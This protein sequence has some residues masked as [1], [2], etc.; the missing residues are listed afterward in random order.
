M[1]RTGQ[2]SAMSKTLPLHLLLVQHL[3]VVIWQNLMW[4]NLD[5]AKT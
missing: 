3:F 2:D 1:K 5:V 4:Q